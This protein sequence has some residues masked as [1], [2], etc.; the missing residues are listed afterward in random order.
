MDFPGCGESNEPFTENYL[1][2]MTSDSNASF[3]Y[4]LEIIENFQGNILVLYGDMDT[5]VPME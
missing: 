2:N 1:S 3:D 4:I 5:T